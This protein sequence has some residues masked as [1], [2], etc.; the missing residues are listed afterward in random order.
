[1]LVN[2]SPSKVKMIWRV[3]HLGFYH[4][5]LMELQCLLLKPQNVSVRGLA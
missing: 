2:G 3:G 4:L 5:M 1:M